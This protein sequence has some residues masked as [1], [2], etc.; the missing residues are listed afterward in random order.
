M[1]DADTIKIVHSLG[2]LAKRQL[3]IHMESQAQ[4]H[5]IGIVFGEIERRSILRKGRQIH[6]EE[7]DVELPIDVV[8]LVSVLLKRM[9]PADFLKVL[10]VVGALVVD[11]FVDTEAGTVF[12]R[13]EDMAA[14]RAFV[15]D[16]FGMDTAINEGSAA[17]LALVLT[18]TAVVV[19]EVLMGSTAD[20]TDLV[21][22]DRAPA[23]VADRIDLL[24]I[25]VFEVSDQEFPVLFE[26]GDDERELIDLELLVL[27]RFGIIMDPLR[28][29]YEFTDKL[30]Q[31]CDL[32]GLMLNDVKKME[33]NVH[34]QLILSRIRFCRKNIVPE[35]GVIALFFVEKA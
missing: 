8:E 9:F 33:Y 17:D 10:P 29:G 26:E 12:D 2:G 35:K 19:I 30:Q 1:R 5:D 6:F 28:D 23:P 21:L 13:N 3:Q 11:A 18:A 20:R 16:R 31:K 34:E 14:I 32:F 22:R 7:V 4:G 15:P 25:L 24:A 27:R